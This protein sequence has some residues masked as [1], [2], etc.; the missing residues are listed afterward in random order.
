M[1]LVINTQKY[2][3]IA[4]LYSCKN[5]L[6]LLSVVCCDFFFSFLL[7]IKPQNCEKDAAGSIMLYGVPFLF[8][9]DIFVK[10]VLAGLLEYTGKISVKFSV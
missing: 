5:Q 4:L 2:C 9:E 1:H 8:K 7:L 6:H 10:L 3:F